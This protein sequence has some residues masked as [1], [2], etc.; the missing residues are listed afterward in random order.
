MSLDKAIQSGK[1]RR[2][3]YH[4]AKAIDHTC[5]NH[6]TCSYCRDNRLISRRKSELVA[7]DKRE[8]FEYGESNQCRKGVQRPSGRRIYLREV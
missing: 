5:R 7:E 2:R 8:E 4:G 1:E 3:P 6:G